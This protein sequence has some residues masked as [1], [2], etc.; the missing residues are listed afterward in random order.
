MSFNKSLFKGIEGTRMTKNI[1]FL[2][3][4]PLL[5]FLKQN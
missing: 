1:L 5:T 4:I 2:E 3:S